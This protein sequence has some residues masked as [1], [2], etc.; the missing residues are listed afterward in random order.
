MLVVALVALAA[1]VA[2]TGD[3][4]G[5]TKA[6]ATVL[7]LNRAVSSDQLVR[8]DGETLRPLS[9]RLAL[10]GHSYAWAF[11]PDGK[12][13]AVG[14]DR[15]LGI[16]IVDVRRLK[17]LTSVKTWNGD[18]YSLA[19]LTPRRI[20]GVEDTGLFAVDPVAQRRIR[21]PHVGGEIE[22]VQRAGNVLAMV[23]AP[24]SAIGSARFV[25]LGADCRPRSVQ[26]DR[27]RAGFVF[28][29]ESRRG[30]SRRPGL[31]F[32]P[33]GR[34]FV[35]GSAGEPVA[36]I[37]LATLAVTYHEPGERRSFFARLRD[38]IEPAAEA[39]MPL[40]GSSRN[41]LWLG[42]GKIAVWGEDSVPVGADRV[43]TTPAGLS[44]ID[45][46]AWTVDIVDRTATEVTRVEETLLATD[47]SIG[48]SGLTGYSLDGERRY[49]LFEGTSAHVWQSLGN[50]AYV[51]AS[52]Q[53]IHAV[54]VTTGRVLRSLRRMPQLLTR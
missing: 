29:E 25:A 27:I 5:R 1:P 51:T 9:K 24:D 43:E 40:A 17:R 33:A 30:E 31:A 53:R 13:L 11:S 26:L 38:W 28:D 34:A 45:T 22:R 37:D 48:S 50:T 18:I 41:A 6:P 47:L 52:R 15:A 23:V 36:E 20:V 2:A 42:D 4:A 3:L 12:R 7:G 32:D 49:R 54:D 35:V 19:W 21:I 44:I 16:R 46:S 14:V 8:L 39:K 10:G